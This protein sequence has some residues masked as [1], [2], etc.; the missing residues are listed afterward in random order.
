MWSFTKFHFAFLIKKKVTYQPTYK[1]LDERKWNSLT[2]VKSVLY[3]MIKK[4]LTLS[5]YF[6][7]IL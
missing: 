1:S 3:R 2:D 5:E 4:M 7:D 6:Y